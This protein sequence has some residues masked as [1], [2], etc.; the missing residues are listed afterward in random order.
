MWTRAYTPGKQHLDMWKIIRF[1]SRNFKFLL[2]IFFF[3]SLLVHVCVCMC[4]N[5]HDCA[6]Q[7]LRAHQGLGAHQGLSGFSPATLWGELG[8]ELRSSG[9]STSAPKAPSLWFNSRFLRCS[10]LSFQAQSAS[11]IYNNYKNNNRSRKSAHG[12]GMSYNITSYNPDSHPRRLS[13]RYRGISKLSSTHS[14]SQSSTVS[15]YQQS[16]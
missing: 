15:K 14:H 11:K 6:S 3:I 2:I 5:S 7:G 9:L 13:L 1:L 16:L 12:L 4:E 10:Y 8:I